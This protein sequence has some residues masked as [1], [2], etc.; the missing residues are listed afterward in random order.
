MAVRTAAR[1]IGER[2]NF[3]LTVKATIDTR[4]VPAGNYQL[5]LRRAGDGW[6]MYPAQVHNVAP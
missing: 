6:R 2:V 3:V 1:G 4:S 5:A